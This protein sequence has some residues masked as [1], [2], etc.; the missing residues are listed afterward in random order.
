M[1]P[2]RWICDRCAGLC[3]D[4]TER[5]RLEINSALLTRLF[6]VTSGITGDAVA[7]PQNPRSLYFRG[8]PEGWEEDPRQV[9]GSQR[10]RLM[11]AMARAVATKGYAKVTV[12]D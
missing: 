11:E 6:A 4:T 2:T 1:R 5:W 8:L 10:E 3:Q 9:A 12:A 7:R